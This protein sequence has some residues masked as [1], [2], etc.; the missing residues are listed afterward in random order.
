VEKRVNYI[1]IEKADFPLMYMYNLQVVINA[2]LEV[3]DI[4]ACW[5]G[6]THDSTIFNHSRIKSLFEAGTFGDSILIADSGYPNLSYVSITI[7]VNSCRA[8]L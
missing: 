3:I 1:E 6:S 2:R 4:V 7:S 8:S 5:P